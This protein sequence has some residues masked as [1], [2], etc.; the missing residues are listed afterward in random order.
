MKRRRTILAVALAAAAL[1]AVSASAVVQAPTQC[2]AAF[3]VLHDDRI[4]SLQLPEGA[5]QLAT[6]DVSCLRASHLFT[7]FLQDYNGRLPQPWRYTVQGTGQGTFIR[8]TS[9]ARFTVVRTGDVTPNTPGHSTDGGGT[10]GALACPAAFEVEHNDRIGPLRL[11]RG[12]YRITRLGPRLSCARASN[13]FARF[14][15]RP[16]GRLPGGWVLLPDL[17]EFVKGSTTYGFMVEPMVSID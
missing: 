5:Y 16:G 4:G 7:E 3:H 6:T 9:S 10:H 13:L 15:D 2:G 14:L 8:G 1:A 17:A 12:D 11:P